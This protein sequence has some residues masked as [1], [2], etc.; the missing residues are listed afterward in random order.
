MTAPNSISDS[1]ALPRITELKKVE[2]DI[3]LADLVGFS[4][5]D[6]E[7]QFV[8]INSVGKT[9]VPLLA[10]LAKQSFG[11][12]VPLAI[13][14]IPTGDGFYLIMHPGAA[15]C[16]V[17]VAMFLRQF[18]LGHVAK[19]A[20]LTGVR[21]GVHHGVAIPFDDVTGRRNFIGSGLN[22]C[23]RLG[24]FDAE[25]M[26][27]IKGFYTDDNWVMVSDAAMGWFQSAYPTE[28]YQ[29]FLDSS[30]WRQS[31]RFQ[32]ADK[33]GKRHAYYLVDANPHIN[34]GIPKMAHIRPDSFAQPW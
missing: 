27:R 8:A 30:G 20:G 9:A 25:S 4:K 5:M 12:E 22:D 24:A 10:G 29:S 23:A 6:D 28:Q 2:T 32:S 7:T 18:L 31:F 26:K 21:F 1:K 17:F 11:R 13:G 16:A 34:F 15:G 19:A 3:I 14:W 33:H